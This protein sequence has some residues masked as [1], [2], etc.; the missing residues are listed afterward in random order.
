M[1]CRDRK[2]R[3]GAP[4]D[5]CAPCGFGCDPCLGS[6]EID[7]GAWIFAN[8]SYPLPDPC[9][10]ILTLSDP[11]CSYGDC[12]YECDVVDTLIYDDPGIVAECVRAVTNCFLI[13]GL[14]FRK[15]YVKEVTMDFTI[16]SSIRTIVQISYSLFFIGDKKLKIGVHISEYKTAKLLNG[17]RNLIYDGHTIAGTCAGTDVEPTEWTL[18]SDITTS[19]E[20]SL[21]CSG[22]YGL[23]P[24]DDYYDRF[25]CGF[26]SVKNPEQT[27]VSMCGEHDP[28]EWIYIHWQSWGYY[29]DTFDLD[30]CDDFYGTFT[31][32]LVAS[33]V[34][35]DSLVIS[36]FSGFCSYFPCV[37]QDLTGT[38][39]PS[40]ITVTLA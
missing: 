34:D 32:P 39:P 30:T 2:H 23:D 10:G 28:P 21:N 36:R 4:C 7:A 31:L 5:G 27:P 35:T 38:T 11:N 16:T 6:V 14:Q 3:P 17:Q 9:T 26:S 12:T 29:E 13:P 20:P 19:P 8:W 15:N 18:R 37:K 24:G 1:A 33:I 22:V 40:E 25:I